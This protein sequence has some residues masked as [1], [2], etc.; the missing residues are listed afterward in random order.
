MQATFRYD[1]FAGTAGDD[2]I[3][4]G[5][6]SFEWEGVPGLTRIIE[7]TVRDNGALMMMSYDGVIWGPEIELD[8]DDPPIQIPHAAR[9]VQIKNLV[10]G[11]N[12]RFQIIGF[13]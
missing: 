13:W 1:V 6:M 4:T 5:I 2:F 10:A 8:Q 9:S 12:S 7:V 11:V 3:D